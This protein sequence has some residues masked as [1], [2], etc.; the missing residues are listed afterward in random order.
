MS[1]ADGLECLP[2]LF[3]CLACVEDPLHPG[4]GICM[5]PTPDGGSGRTGLPCF[6]NPERGT[7]RAGGGFER[8]AD[9]TYLTLATLN[10]TELEGLSGDGP[11]R[12]LILGGVGVPGITRYE[13]VFQQDTY[14]IAPSSAL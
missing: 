3:P 8:F 10:C 6:Y 14:F 1:C 13:V 11:L 5:E 9:H 12:D 4:R 2:E 7:V